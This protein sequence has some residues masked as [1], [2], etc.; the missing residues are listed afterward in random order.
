MSRAALSP[1]AL[2]GSLGREGQ[3]CLTRRL[4]IPFMA[5]GVGRIWEP[6]KDKRFTA[7][8]AGVGPC[9]EP[10]WQESLAHLVAANLGDAVTHQ[11]VTL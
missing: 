1:G 10:L 5:S 7:V 8:T 6:D 2:R 9:R 11:K 4:G 3:A